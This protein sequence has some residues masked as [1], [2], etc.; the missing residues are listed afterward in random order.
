MWRRLDCLKASVW[1]FQLTKELFV[2]YNFAPFNDGSAVTAVKRLFEL[3]CKADVVSCD[4]SSVRNRDASLLELVRDKIDRHAII[5][6]VV[7]FAH[8]DSI[9]DFVTKGWASIDEWNENYRSIYSRSMWVH[10]HFLA[11]VARSRCASQHWNAE[12]SDPLLWNVDGSVRQTADVEIS[13]LLARELLGL[14]PTDIQGLLVN[15]RRVVYWAQIVTF[16]V[17]DILTF[18]NEQQAQLMISDVPQEYRRQLWEKT[19]ISPHPTL[20]AHLYGVGDDNRDS[21]VEKYKLGYFGNFY[22]N[23]GS[24]TF[25]EAWASLPDETANRVQLSVYS[26]S[27][28]GL[29]YYATNLGLADRIQIHKPLTFLSFLRILNQFDGLLVSD[30]S[31]RPFTVPCPYLPSKVSDYKGA[32]SEMVALYLDGSPLSTFDVGRRADVNSIADIRRLLQDLA[33]GPS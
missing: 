28:A 6:S 29:D 16:F 8:W 4:L 30:I 7:R 1:D 9:C 25:L 27:A 3:D 11:A 2:A 26:D 21:G 22:A 14:V 10:S 24:S 32:T 31:T 12:F 17:A 18:T 20:P 23:R 19:A 15:D 5:K 33:V 13:S